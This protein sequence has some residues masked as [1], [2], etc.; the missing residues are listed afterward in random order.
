[1]M[2]PRGMP[3]L[4]TSEMHHRLASL[5]TESLAGPAL[6]LDAA[7]R[8]IWAS[9]G[10]D[11]LL[12]EPATIG[13]LAPKLLCG[14]AL[15]R[16]IAEA[17]V[18]GRAVSGVVLRS[19]RNGTVRALRVRATPLREG[20]T[21]AGW[22]MLLDEQTEVPS[23]APDAPMLFHGMWTRDTAMKQVFHVMKRAALRDVPVLVRGE[24]GVGKELVARAIHDLSPRT[25]GPFRAINCAA[26]PPSLLESE[27]FGHVKGAFTG[28]LRDQPGIFRSTDR[29][30]LFLD[31]I[32][33]MSLDLQ[34]RLLRVLET[35]TVIPVGGSEQVAV[36]VRIVAATHQSLRRSVERGNFR[37]D[38]MYRLRVVPLFLPPLRARQGDIALLTT[39]VVEELNAT[40]QRQVARVAPGALSAL[41]RYTWPGNVREL[42]NALEYAFVIGEGPVLTETDLPPEITS[43]EPDDLSPPA[44]NQPPAPHPSCPRTRWRQP[45]ARCKNPWHE[46]SH[47]L[48]SHARTFTPVRCVVSHN[49]HTMQSCISWFPRMHTAVAITNQAKPRRNVSASTRPVRRLPRRLPHTDAAITGSTTPQVTCV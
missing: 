5:A 45:N 22:L 31:E 3:R 11:I 13:T 42:R 15:Q 16:P 41:M 35:H 30:T 2:Y 39:R 46:P 14:N 48:A 1:M 26:L 28:A 17:L 6:L 10:V 23:D 33:E 37:A 21:T 9:P 38:L 49:H 18:A 4:P 34:A 47:S 32:A 20:D 36:D 40:G 7:L 27:L 25:R 8:V 29:G 24:T 44:V 43:P 19:R 12:G